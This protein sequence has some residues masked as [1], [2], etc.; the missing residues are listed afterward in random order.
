VQL[1][2]LETLFGQV[3][4]WEGLYLVDQLERRELADLLGLLLQVVQLE[5][6]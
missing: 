6:L 3:V 2:Q 4:L 1:L 5:D